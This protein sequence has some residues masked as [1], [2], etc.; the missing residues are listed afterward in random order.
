MNDERDPREDDA[1]EPAPETGSRPRTGRTRRGPGR[2]PLDP[3]ERKDKVLHARIPESLDAELRREARKLR[4]PVSNL[5]RNILEDT[6]HLVDDIVADSLTIADTVRRDAK[7]V[8]EAAARGYG[9]FRARQE[10]AQAPDEDGAETDGEGADPEAS[11]ESADSL[12]DIYGWQGLRAS[13]DE[14]CCRCSREIPRGDEAFL[15]Q[16][17]VPGAPRRWLCAPCMEDW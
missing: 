13:R 12:D 2:P 4:M 11:A 6:L 14:T 8:A 16:S 15:G 1:K 3:E 5:V 7:G 9:A 17:D 10:G